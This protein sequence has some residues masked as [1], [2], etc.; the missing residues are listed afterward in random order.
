VWVGKQ[1]LLID[2]EQLSHSHQVRDIFP[3][4]DFDFD[5]SSFDAD[6]ALI[7]LELDVDLSRRFVVG[8]VCLPSPNAGHVAGIGKVAGWG[9][10]EWSTANGE[11]H[12]FTPNELELPAV[13]RDV[14]LAA[15]IHFQVFTSPRTFCAGY[16]NQ[17]KSVCVGD[18]G[19]GFFQFEEITR[20]FKLVGIVSS[21]LRNPNGGCRVDTY[22]V[23]TN[24]AKFIEWIGR[25]M[26]ET[27]VKRWQIVDFACKN[28]P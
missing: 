2:N 18:S 1:N 17:N 19:G 8:V 12:S 21:S 7:V 15:D 10:S 6:L 26:N 9:V 4:E 24:V 13:T 11:Q 14:C 27:M 23:F 22:S 28:N 3:H 25:K 5:S 16:M 20:S